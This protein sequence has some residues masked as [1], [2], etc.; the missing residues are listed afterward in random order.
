MTT[1][2][3]EHHEL[4]APVTREFN[5]RAAVGRKGEVRSLGSHGDPFQIGGRQLASVL[6][7]KILRIRFGH[8]TGR[9]KQGQEQW[10]TCD[11]RWSD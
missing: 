4:P 2:K 5:R 7:S 3:D 11:E 6:G 9:R 8:G 1:V 10:D